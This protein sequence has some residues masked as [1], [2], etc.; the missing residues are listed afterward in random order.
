[1]FAPKEFDIISVNGHYELHHNG[2]FYCSAD[3]YRE[4]LSEQEIKLK[5]DA[6]MQKIPGNHCPY[7]CYPKFE[8][9]PIDCNIGCEK[10]R[11]TFF[12]EAE[13]AIRQNIN[14]FDTESGNK[15]WFL[16]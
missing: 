5:L 4:A 13:E 8:H 3:T 9:V 14:H 7:S 6:I 12:F 1:M 15:S 11:N 10:C 16:K 2:E